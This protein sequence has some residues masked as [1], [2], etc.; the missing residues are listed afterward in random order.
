MS[1]FYLSNRGQ[2]STINYFIRLNSNPVLT[3]WNSKTLGDRIKK[4]LS[5]TFTLSGNLVKG[6]G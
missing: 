5:R 1:G 6:Y 2:K 4:Y 3:M